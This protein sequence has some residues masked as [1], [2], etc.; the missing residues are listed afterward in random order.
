MGDVVDITSK[1]VIDDGGAQPI[2]IIPA[3]AAVDGGLNAQ[4]QGVITLNLLDVG[5]DGQPVPTHRI[6]MLAETWYQI[7]QML[8]QS[9]AQLEIASVKYRQ[10]HARRI[11]NERRQ[12][13]GG[14]ILPPSLEVTPNGTGSDEP[15]S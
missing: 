12:A 4:G 11:E 13:H 8:A 10:Q 2:V 5:P 9:A 15:A 1:Q 7:G 3:G 6:T 14:L